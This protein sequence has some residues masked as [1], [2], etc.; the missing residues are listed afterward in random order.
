[1]TRKDYQLIARV[2]R[3]ALDNGQVTTRGEADLFCDLAL[4]LANK[5]EADN[6][7]FSR[8]TFLDACGGE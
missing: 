8:K 5:L 6:P 4:Q 3:D 7:R 1:M 2:F